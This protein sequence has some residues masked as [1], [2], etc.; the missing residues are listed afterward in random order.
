MRR[1]GPIARQ[2]KIDR[3][4][5]CVA[6]CALALAANVQ[7][8][9]ARQMEWKAAVLIRG[10]Y[11]TSSKLFNNPD[12]PTTDLRNDYTPIDGMTGGGIEVRYPLEDVNLYLALSVDLNSKQSQENLRTSFGGTVRRL[13][14][15]EG[16]RFIPVE[17][18]ANT[19]IP[20]GS[21]SMMLSMG[22][23]I[24]M[25]YAARTLTVAGVATNV[26][27]NPYSVGIHVGLGFEYKIFT[28]IF[29]AFGM[30]FRDP[31][32]I[33]ESRFTQDYVDYEGSRVTFPQDP[34]KTKINIDGMSLSLG[35]VF[36]LE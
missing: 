31:E 23:G 27:N 25:Y 16:L 5:W 24:G 12:A 1:A 11:I 19:F 36:R 30:K 26:S 8:V 15:T 14:V 2:S 22:G 10:N 20:L 6:A 21:E 3:H 18:S 13:P 32:I 34:M 4:L 29:A 28:D 35:F 17:L 9:V 7:Q 33:S